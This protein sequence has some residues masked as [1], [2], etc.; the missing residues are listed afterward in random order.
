MEGKGY[1]ERRANRED[2]DQLGRGREGQ[3]GMGCFP[4]KPLERGN[5]R[6]VVSLLLNEQHAVKL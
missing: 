5:R 1:E 4:F 6:T 2:T 3:E